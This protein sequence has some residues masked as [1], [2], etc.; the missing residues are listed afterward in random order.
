[1]QE[2]KILMVDDEENV[3]RS[4]K[5]S[6]IGE[7]YE[8][9]TAGSAEEALEKL[10]RFPAD[11]VLSDNMMPGMTGLEF[12]QQVKQ[13]YP[14]SIRILLTARAEV[15]ITIEAIKKG[16][17]FRFLLKPWDD[18]EL[19]MTIRIAV[20]ITPHYLNHHSRPGTPHYLN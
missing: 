6:L 3:L 14:D 1:M 10:K 8:I 17:I 2:R 5:R 20:N 9:E 18:G 12:L 13:Q 11:I 16:E 15:Q 7:D 4:L 19:Q